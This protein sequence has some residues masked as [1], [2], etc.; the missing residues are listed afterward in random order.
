MLQESEVRLAQAR[1]AS[2]EELKSLVH[3]ASGEVI[4]ALLENPCIEEFHIEIL[5]ERLDL[6]VQVLAAIGGDGKWTSKEGVRLCLARHPRTPKR[7]ALA[8]VRQLFLVDLVRLCLLPSAPADIK[9]VAEQV[10][11]SRVPHL[12]VGEKLMLARRGPA[13]VA[14]A[15]LAEGHPQAVKLALSNRFL[16]ES[17]VLKTLAKPEIPERVVTAIAKDGKWSHQYNVR[18]A[19]IRNPHTPPTLVR[20]FLPD[21]TLRDL[22]DIASLEDLPPQRK[23]H[24]AQEMA[25]RKASPGTSPERVASDS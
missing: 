18:V 17:Q 1:A 7:I 3:E 15:L 11:V 24:I 5:L 12:P 19:L 25:R 4:L 16:T 21:L 22:K 10:I 6:P 2:T 8:V 23:A 9:R 14:G 20:E 13:H